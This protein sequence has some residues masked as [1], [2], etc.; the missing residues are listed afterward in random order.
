MGW[1]IGM[2]GVWG[3]GGGG[4]LGGGGSVFLIYEVVVFFG[5]FGNNALL[6]KTILHITVV[7]WMNTINR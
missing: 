2:G 1:G 4:V 3:F 6:S 5:F 7:S